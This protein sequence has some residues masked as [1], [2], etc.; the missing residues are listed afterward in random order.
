MSPLSFGDLSNVSCMNGLGFVPTY[1]SYYNNATENNNQEPESGQTWRPQWLSFLPNQVP[2]RKYVQSTMP[3]E[4]TSSNWVKNRAQPHRNWEEVAYQQNLKQAAKACA[5]ACASDD[6]DIVANAYFM[7]SSDIFSQDVILDPECLSEGGGST[8]ASKN[9]KN[10]AT[11]GYFQSLYSNPIKSTQES[12]YSKLNV[13]VRPLLLSGLNTRMNR[14]FGWAG[15]CWTLAMVMDLSI[16]INRIENDMQFCPSP[17][18]FNAHPMGWYD[19]G[20]GASINKLDHVW[21]WNGVDPLEKFDEDNATYFTCNISDVMM[22]KLREKASTKNI[23]TLENMT[24]ANA[25]ND[26]SNY[27]LSDPYWSQDYIAPRQRYVYTASPV[28]TEQYGPILACDSNSDANDEEIQNPAGKSSDTPWDKVLCST[29]FEEAPCLR[30]YS[31]PSYSKKGMDDALNLYRYDVNN[32]YV[33]EQ[34]KFYGSLCEKSVELC[35]SSNDC[36]LNK[37]FGQLDI[38]TEFGKSAKDTRVYECL[39]QGDYGR[40][41]ATYSP[42]NVFYSS[43][44]NLGRLDS[45][46]HDRTFWSL[47]SFKNKKRLKERIQKYAIDANTTLKRLE[48]EDQMV[49]QRN[50]GLMKAIKAWD[51][52]SEDYHQYTVREYLKEMNQTWNI[53]RLSKLVNITYPNEIE[54]EY[55]DQFEV[56]GVSIKVPM[57][58]YDTTAWL[59]ETVSPKLIFNWISLKTPINLFLKQCGGH[60]QNFCPGNII[61]SILHDLSP[62][63]TRSVEYGDV[64]AAGVNGREREYSI[65]SAKDLLKKNLDKRKKFARRI[66]STWIFLNWIRLLGLFVEIVALFYL[67][68]KVL[69]RRFSAQP[70]QR[71]HWLYLFLNRSAGERVSKVKSKAEHARN[72]SKKSAQNLLQKASGKSPDDSNNDHALLHS[73]LSNENRDIGGSNSDDSDSVEAYLKKKK[74]ARETYIVPAR[75]RASVMIAFALCILSCAM[76]LNLWIFCFTASNVG[77]GA[78]TQLMSGIDDPGGSLSKFLQYSGP[79]V[80]DKVKKQMAAEGI[81]SKKLQVERLRKLADEATHGIFTQSKKT[82]TEMNGLMLNFSFEGVHM[83]NVSLPTGAVYMLNTG[84]NNCISNITTDNPS[85]NTILSNAI[86][87]ISTDTLNYVEKNFNEQLNE[88]GGS[89]GLSNDMLTLYNKI[90]EKQFG[91]SVKINHSVVHFEQKCNTMMKTVLVNLNTCM[92]QV[93]TNMASVV[94]SPPATALKSL[95]ITYSIFQDRTA[96]VLKKRYSLFSN[97]TV[98]NSICQTS[99]DKVQHAI[100]RSWQ[101]I[102]S[103][104]NLINQSVGFALKSNSLGLKNAFSNIP[105]IQGEDVYDYL[106]SKTTTA[107]NGT[108]KNVLSFATTFV[109]DLIGNMFDDN[110]NIK[111]LQ[112]LVHVCFPNITFAGQGLMENY[113]YNSENEGSKTEEESKTECKK[114][115]GIGMNLEKTQIYITVKTIIDVF[116]VVGIAGSILC[117]LAVFIVTFQMYTFVS[118]LKQHGMQQAKSVTTFYDPVLGY[119]ISLRNGLMTLTD[120]CGVIGRLPTKDEVEFAGSWSAEERQQPSNIRWFAKK[121]AYCNLMH[122]PNFMGAFVFINAFGFWIYQVLLVLFGTIVGVYPAWIALF[123]MVGLWLPLTLAFLS[124]FLMGECIKRKVLRD[125]KPFHRGI[126]FPVAFTLFDTIYS[127]LGAILGWASALT[128]MFS[129]FLISLLL[130]PRLDLPLPGSF[131]DNSY[132]SYLGLM[133]SSRQR[134]EYQKLITFSEEVQLQSNM[135]VESKTDVRSVDVESPLHEFG[136]NAI[137]LTKKKDQHKINREERRKIVKNKREFTG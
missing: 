21:K 57:T 73:E 52:Y 101:N 14:F 122:V 121:M 60:Y 61:N 43:N 50:D 94:P 114:K 39:S 88:G 90:N 35:I 1:R 109:N 20:N 68:T 95:N 12:F 65:G 54:K 136:S 36:I 38:T 29:S 113:N 132:N 22:Q 3:T 135:N 34:G 42:Y 59:E 107:T 100:D 15:L 18:D 40:S 110:T 56:K 24:Y 51:G 126:Q 92:D 76:S 128:R 120:V 62:P 4:D 116:M 5:A 13:Y 93:A 84:I 119:K 104:E 83:P 117:V 86:R 49:K 103:L 66:G 69:V 63:G 115:L 108:D 11:C 77:R 33:S 106:I 45:C 19:M 55:R 27:D 17:F 46:A 8:C 105:G 99:A 31:V 87:N 85:I 28:P 134:L 75:V 37:T 16:F 74:K 10:F 111:H 125:E 82:M 30:S 23:R 71:C 133:E 72:V 41:V 98:P 130:L 26:N 112:Q 79:I 129:S 67:A 2:W 53:S 102:L 81:N 118:K 123:K 89:A 64:L 131:A 91:L 9:T 47:R 32:Q 6:I 97:T 58:F 48:E 124:K 96:Q 7:A 80:L 25:T 127:M 70:D 44:L 78:L 137:E